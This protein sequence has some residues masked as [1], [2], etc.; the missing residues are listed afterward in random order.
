VQM[1]EGAGHYLV[2]EKPEVAGPALI[3]F[4]QRVI[5]AKEL[6]DGVTGRID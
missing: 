1:V 6:S 3:Q 5:Q 2:A 4:F